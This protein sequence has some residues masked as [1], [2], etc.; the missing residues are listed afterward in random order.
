MTLV[1]L[2]GCQGVPE[3]AKIELVESFYASCGI[4]WK[5]FYSEEIYVCVFDAEGD[6]EKLCE[7]EIAS[8]PKQECLALYQDS[9][10]GTG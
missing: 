2:T 8:G 6:C 4:P 3:E 9:E 10:S 7:C 1:L 5:P